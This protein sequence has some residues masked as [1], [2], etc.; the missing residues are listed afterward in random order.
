MDQKTQSDLVFRC[1]EASFQKIDGLDNVLYDERLIEACLKIDEESTGFNV[2]T[3]LEQWRALLAV[4]L[5]L[6]SNGVLTAFSSLL[7]N[8]WRHLRTVAP[9]PEFQLILAYQAVIAVLLDTP[10]KEL[11]ISQFPSG[12]CST[13]TSG[14]SLSGEV[15]QPVFHAELGSL[16]FLYAK[17]TSS[18]HILAA[19]L[20]LTEWQKNT[21]DHACVPFC[22]LFA[23]EG[24]ISEKSLI[25]HNFLLFN[26]AGKTS[27]EFKSIA[28]NLYQ[29]I[30]SQNLFD[31][32]AYLVALSKVFPLDAAED[33]QAQSLLLSS[34]EDT[35]IG[36]VGFRSPTFSG[37][38]ALFGR[39]SGMGCIHAGDVRIV[40]LGPQYMPL[41]DCRGFGIDG[42][43][44]LL[45]N[46]LKDVH[47][48]DNQS[49]IKGTS[50]MVSAS[51]KND[52]FTSGASGIWIDV[53]QTW[54][55]KEMKLEVMFREVLEREALAFSFFVR[56]QICKMENGKI[57]KRRSLNRY[58]GP[59]TFIHFEGETSSL[60]LIS[61]EQHEEMHIIPLGGGD[62]FWGAD[63]LVSCLLHP[64]SSHFKWTFRFID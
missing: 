48:G 54:K 29:Q 40:C 17:I 64:G 4:T 38:S 60:A 62:N 43:G 25:I 33:N 10:W 6:Q 35:S 57:I 49:V 24:E 9:W 31:I 45:K 58:L 5:K 13:D 21:L 37:V 19:A 46:Y 15:P 47:T 41:N 56:A 59:S 26:A 28:Q 11:E 42:D 30:E 20:R 14:Y 18:T 32:P 22:G 2:L 27:E 61:E 44:R 12:A 36:L 7:L 1:L 8:Q 53:Q 39:G 34:I 16:L 52:F 50:R 63:F 51:L 55:D 3:A 23:K